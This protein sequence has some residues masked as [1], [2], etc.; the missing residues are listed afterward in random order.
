MQGLNIYVGKKHIIGSS[1]S[2]IMKLRCVERQG[3]MEAEGRGTQVGCSVHAQA[4]TFAFINTHLFGE[5]DPTTLLGAL[6]HVLGGERV[7]ALGGGCP[8]S[9]QGLSWGCYPPMM[10]GPELLIALIQDPLIFQIAA[11]KVIYQRLSLIRW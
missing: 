6:Q 4:I 5:R 2:E 3:D 11:V 8:G 7:P 1:R 10:C 9:M